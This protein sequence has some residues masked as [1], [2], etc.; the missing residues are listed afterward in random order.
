MTLPVW[1]QAVFIVFVA[2]SSGYAWGR[3]TG[4]GRKG[5]TPMAHSFVHWQTLPSGWAKNY[6]NLTGYTFFDNGHY[7]WWVVRGSKTIIEGPAR[8]LELA[9]YEVEAAVSEFRREA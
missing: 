2:F 3:A 1:V 4:Y 5:A 7:Y 8:T 6:G 9:Q